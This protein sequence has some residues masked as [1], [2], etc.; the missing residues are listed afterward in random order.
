M[1]DGASSML[2]AVQG[3]DTLV[4]GTISKGR[5]DQGS[6]H[7]R[8]F[9]RDTSVG[10]TSTLHPTIGAK[11]ITSRRTGTERMLIERVQKDKQAH[12][13]ANV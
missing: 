12:T 10:D 6:Q 9:V 7:P 2:D 5:F 13:L 3:R 1:A 8:N 4:R 11:K